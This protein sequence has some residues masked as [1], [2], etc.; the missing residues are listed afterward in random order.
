MQFC[1]DGV[2]GS[3]TDGVYLAAKGEVRRKIQVCDTLSY[4]VT[5]YLKAQQNYVLAEGSGD[6]QLLQKRDKEK[7]K[8]VDVGESGQKWYAVLDEER[9]Q[10]YLSDNNLESGYFV[11]YFPNGAQ[12]SFTDDNN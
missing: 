6:Y 10:V 4:P 1:G 7:I 5:L 8:F 9:N 12:G 11:T 2:F 3:G